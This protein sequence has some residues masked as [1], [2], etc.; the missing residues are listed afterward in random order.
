MFA[1][2]L[3]AGALDSHPCLP[4]DRPTTRAPVDLTSG[5][6]RE[7]E[8]VADA[9]L[10]RFAGPLAAPCKRIVHAPG[11]RLRPALA[12]ACARL[13]TP[14][15]E[16]TVMGLAAA[17]ELLHAATLVHDDVIDGAH[18]RRGVDTVNAREGVA[19]AIIAGDAL[20]ATA[21]GL[22]GQL[23]AA[24]GG[25]LVRT[26]ADLCAGQAAE[27]GLRHRPAAD[28]EDVLAAAALKTGSLL[29]AACTVGALAGGLGGDLLDALG[30][31]G[32]R[33][34]V[35]LQMVDDV[36]DFVSTEALLGKP[37]EADL[38]AG[39]LSTPIVHC[40]TTNPELAALIGAPQHTAASRLALRLVRDS[41]AL[42]V[43]VDG[44]HRHAAVA[45]ERLRA[46]APGRADVAA[47][48]ACVGDFVEDQLRTKTHPRWRE[49]VMYRPELEASSS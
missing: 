7:L 24:A 5:E 30:D 41:D 23:D 3:P 20:I 45:A 14:R 16:H 22:A 28:L 37:V 31:F 12:L 42:A 17:V 43:S 48:A 27:E 19:T 10:A 35:C 46:V 47:L 26:L 1:Q 21:L 11:R 8:V 4:V 40:L 13:G 33:F 2:S 25:V 18:T 38:S 39:V 29:R 32:S 44:A 9:A 36:L 49:L 34:G 15:D 6:R